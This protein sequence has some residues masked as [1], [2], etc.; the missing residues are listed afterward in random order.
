[1]QKSEEYNHL[2]QEIGRNSQ[3]IQNVFVANV[4]VTSGLIGYGLSS[5]YGL[6]FLSPLAII[7]PS[8]FFLASQLESTTRIAAYLLVFHER[9]NPVLNWETRWL[10]I[11][12]RGLLPSKRKYTF[13]LTGLYGLISMLCI[14]LAYKYWTSTDLWFVASMLPIVTLLAL[15]IR[16]VTQAL[17]L[18]L[19]ESYISSWEALKG[20]RHEDA[21]L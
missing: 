21:R 13:S 6:I 14:A 8:L 16:S 12:K 3:I 5:E 4:A 1:M 7:L 15:G 11:R 19:I 17:S 10:E 2:Y 18:E 20:M 9:E